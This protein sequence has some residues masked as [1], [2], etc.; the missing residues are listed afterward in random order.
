MNFSLQTFTVNMLTSSPFLGAG[1]TW[2]WALLPLLQRH[3]L[4]SSLAIKSVRFM[5]YSGYTSRW[6]LR[7]L[8][9]G[10]QKLE[11]QPRP[12]GKMIRTAKH[13]PLQNHYM[14]E[15]GQCMYD[16]TLRCF[17]VTTT[18]VEK[19]QLLHILNVCL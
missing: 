19:Q 5:I 9:G 17:H 16:I 15:D 3:I 7:P 2:K 4:N 18:A 10:A 8:V 14:K 12:V 13:N 1:K 11:S 6:H